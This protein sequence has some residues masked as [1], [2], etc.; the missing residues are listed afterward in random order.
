MVNYYLFHYYNQRNNTIAEY[1]MIAKFLKDP[2]QHITDYYQKM[3]TKLM[4][5]RENNRIER[6]LAIK[7]AGIRMLEK[8]AAKKKIEREAKQALIKAQ[9]EREAIRKR[10]KDETDEF[11]RRR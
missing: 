5:F 4:V 1:L 10:I 8:K 9:K 3:K 2:L 11:N 6:D 7:Q